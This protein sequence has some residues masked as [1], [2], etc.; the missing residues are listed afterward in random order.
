MLKLNYHLQ[1]GSTQKLVHP[2][3][4][5][6]PA[7]VQAGIDKQDW[8]V[9]MAAALQLA[10]ASQQVRAATL[11]AQAVDRMNRSGSSVHVAAKGMPVLQQA[12]RH[13]DVVK[14]TA[15]ACPV[16]CALWLCQTL[17]LRCLSLPTVAMSSK[18]S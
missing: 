13:A 5:A 9:A 16:D 7:L 18:G 8:S 10:H 2:P 15:H 12:E 3:S 11:I 17:P 6:L 4:D 1:L 14:V